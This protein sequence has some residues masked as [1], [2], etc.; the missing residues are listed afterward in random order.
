MQ[1]TCLFDPPPA[2]VAPRPADHA[3]LTWKDVL[4]GEREKEYF[5]SIMAFIER[6]RAAGKTIYPKNSDIFNALAFTPFAAVKVVLVGQDPYHGPHQAHGLSFSVLPGVPPP[7]SLVNIFKEIA[8][9]VGAPVPN[10]GCLEKWAR[11]GVLLLNAVLTVEAARPESHRGIGWEQFTGRIIQELNDRKEGLVFLLWGAH[12]QE[13]CAN[14]DVLKHTILKAPHP[15]PFSAMRGFFGCKHFSK[16]N[17]ILVKQQQT[18]I[19]WSL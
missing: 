14:I 6:E 2:A 19:D 18:P 3:P 15:S 8:D 5:K 4:H 16:T 10:H 12:A 9:D 17:A 1:Q 7:P 13:K 11:E